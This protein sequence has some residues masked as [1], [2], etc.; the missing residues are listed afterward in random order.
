MACLCPQFVM[1]FLTLSFCCGPCIIHFMWGT[2]GGHCTALHWSPW[3]ACHHVRSPGGASPHRVQAVGRNLPFL[4]SSSLWHARI[5]ARL[6]AHLLVCICAYVPV[7]IC[8]LRLYVSW[9]HRSH[10]RSG[11]KK[12]TAIVSRVMLFVPLLS[13]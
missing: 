2:I 4:V 9:V 5:T 12:L 10:I 11:Q 13:F 7:C 8:P 1:L 3:R 6:S